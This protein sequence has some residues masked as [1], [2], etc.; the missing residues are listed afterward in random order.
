[1]QLGRPSA[2]TGNKRSNVEQKRSEGESWKTPLQKV[3]DDQERHRPLHGSS[4]RVNVFSVQRTQLVEYPNAPGKLT[5]YRRPP[6]RIAFSHS[7]S[8]HA[9]FLLFPVPWT[10]R[11]LNG[12]FDAHRTPSQLSHFLLSIK[13]ARLSKQKLRSHALAALEEESG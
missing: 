13:G 9:F 3:R 2:P 8:S 12:F 4:T 5:N 11:T 7:T 10:R 6:R 1:M